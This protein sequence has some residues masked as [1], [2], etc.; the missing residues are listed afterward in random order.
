L[1]V[2]DALPEMPVFLYPDRFVRV[3]LE[4]AYSEAFPRLAKKF[5]AVL[6]A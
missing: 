2:G 5:Q 1:R 6:E 4:R 3:P